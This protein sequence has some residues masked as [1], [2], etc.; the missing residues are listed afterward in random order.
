MHVGVLQ[1]V[2]LPLSTYV[3]WYQKTS[4]RSPP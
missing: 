4:C 3:H 2:Q 1:Q